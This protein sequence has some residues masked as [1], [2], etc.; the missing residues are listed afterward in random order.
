M[1]ADFASDSGGNPADQQ[2]FKTEVELL[3]SLISLGFIVVVV[4]LYF[5]KRYKET[6]QKAA[7]DKRIYSY[8]FIPLL[9]LGAVCLWFVLFQASTFNTKSSLIP[10][11]AAPAASKPE[12]SKKVA[13]SNNLGFLNFL[14]EAE[15]KQKKEERPEKE[16]EGSKTRKKILWWLICAVCLL[17]VYLKRMK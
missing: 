4:I 2:H 6:K 17:L 14:G 12:T 7:E 15:V 9:M 13:S 10:S 16:S 11:A 8:V 3:A 5:F 1:E